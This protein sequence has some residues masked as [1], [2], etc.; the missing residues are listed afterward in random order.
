MIMKP[1]IQTN[2]K[3]VKNDISKYRILILSFVILVASLAII[4]RLF[5][6]QVIEHKTYIALASGQYEIFQKL[7]PKRGQIYIKEDTDNLLSE[8]NNNLYPLAT[9]KTVYEV[10]AQPKFINDPF[11]TTRQ[12]V[13]FFNLQDDEI[14]HEILNKLSKKDDPYEPLFKKVDQAQVEKL[15]ELEI[16]GIGFKQVLFRYY[17]E[18][19]LASNVLGFVRHDDN[20]Y[21]GQYGIEGY[22]NA[23]LSG[24][25]GYLRSER[26]AVGRWI[27]VSDRQFEQAQ[28]G[29]DLVLSINKSIQYIGCE[30]IKKAYE[31]YEAES[32]TLT[33]M[34]PQTGAIIA[35]CNY[36]NFNPN[37]YGQV[38]DIT[39]FNNKAIFDAYEPG[40][41][42][43]PITL[44]GAI[45]TKKVDPNT[46]YH[47][48]GFIPYNNKGEVDY[49]EASIEYRLK[50]Y[51]LKVHGDVTMTEVLEKSVNT[52]TIY[53]MQQTGTKDFKKY[54]R[55]FGFGKLTGIELDTE[56]A[57]D[58]S[59]LDKK[60]ELFS[61]TASYGQGITATPLQMITAYSVFAN[62]GKLVKPYIISEKK[63]SDGTSEITEPKIIRQPISGRTASLITGML[64]SVVDNGHAKHA[65]VPGYYIAGKTGTA[66]IA[67]EGGYGDETIHSFVGYGPS[68]NPRFVMIIRID[69]PKKGETSSQTAA[70]VFGDI[71]KFILDYYNV[72]PE[73]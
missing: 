73:R 19:E 48:I 6:L 60:A 67:A 38:E 44:S 22:F 30:K 61:A 54:V 42:F 28:D 40:S 21:I 58:I 34:D 1:Y 35:M 52:G 32:V 3:H 29:I 70:K 49:D 26:D 43:K 9:N 14:K 10:Y 17:P 51:D 37:E 16:E 59:S 2:K 8:I 27:A 47:D 45:D 7:F 64:I 20:T 4:W 72:P 65:A 23:E 15:Q 66:Q 5:V 31:E 13:E 12:L 41:I 18:N 39:Y 57:G 46:I 62:G 36:P 24:K 63:Y 68:D 25:Q 11:E 56:S 69:K 33:I 53:A 50:N 71:A 55:D